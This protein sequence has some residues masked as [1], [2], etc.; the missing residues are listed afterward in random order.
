MIDVATGEGFKLFCCDE[1]ESRIDFRHVA[2]AMMDGDIYLLTHTTSGSAP[3][4][5]RK[6]NGWCVDGV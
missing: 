2:S 1:D 6:L 4:H 3:Y 5:A